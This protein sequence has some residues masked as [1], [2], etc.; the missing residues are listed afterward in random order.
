MLHF[1]W[2]RKLNLAAWG[3]SQKIGATVWADLDPDK[4]GSLEE[5]KIKFNELTDLCREHVREKALELLSQTKGL[6]VIDASGKV[7]SNFPY[8]IVEKVIVEMP[9]AT[10]PGH[11]KNQ[12]SV[13]ATE[14]ELGYEIPEDNLADSME[15]TNY[16]PAGTQDFPG[17]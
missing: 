12:R 6:Q 4:E 10:P 3:E 7:I 11:N 2:E 17:T 13:S 9:K 15:G 14:A 1:T 8:V 5:A 16:P